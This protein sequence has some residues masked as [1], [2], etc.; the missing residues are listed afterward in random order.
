MMQFFFAPV[1]GKLSDRSGRRPFLFISLGGYMISMMLFGIG[2]NLQVLYAARIVAGILSAALLPVA[3]AHVADTTADTQPG[4]AIAWLGS[5]IG[6]GVVVGPLLGSI[7]S[8]INWNFNIRFAHFLLDSFSIPFIVAAAMA[9]TAL[10]L[11]AL[12][13]PETIQKEVVAQTAQK[14]SAGS[15]K[16]FDIVK[17]GLCGYLGKLVLLSFTSQFALPLFEGT[18]A[19]HAER[20]RVFGPIQMGMVFMT[21]G[22]V[23]AGCK[24][25]LWPGLCRTEEKNPCC[26]SVAA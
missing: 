15:S 20:V 6:L 9:L 5:S 16:S 26:Q 12:F 22:F 10:V 2:A 25:V 13:M 7:L 18:F 23:M 19:L 24:T 1:W 11:V 17:K 14:N 4:R 3:N 8:R 21:C